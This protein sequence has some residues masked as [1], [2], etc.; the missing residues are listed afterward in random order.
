MARQ[1]GES[2]GPVLVIEVLELPERAQEGGWSQMS[3]RSRSSCRQ[4]CTQR[5]MIEFILGVWI[6][7]STTLIPASMSTASNKPGNLPS[8]SRI[9][10]RAWALASSRSM[11]RFF[12]A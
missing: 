6:P 10:N 2:G 9:K 7:L 5:S 11:T 4:V 1:L 8:R 12:A 3:V